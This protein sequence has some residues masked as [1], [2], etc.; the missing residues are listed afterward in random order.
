MIAEDLVEKILKRDERTRKL[1][2]GAFARDELPSQPPFPSCFIINTDPRDRPGAHWLAVHYNER[3]QADFFDSYA[4]DPSYFGLEAYIYR[5]SNGF[6][7]NSK[8][9]QGDFPFCGIYCILFLLYKCRGQENT[10]FNQFTKNLKQND[11]LIQ[12]LIKE[13]I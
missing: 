3:G 8:R 10:F 6:C 7:F 12:T 9:I 1:F 2:L 13:F 5:T 4:H 11:K